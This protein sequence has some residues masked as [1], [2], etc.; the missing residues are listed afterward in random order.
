M[1]FIPLLCTPK[2]NRMNIL[3]IGAN[4]QIGQKI[5]DKIHSNSPHDAI[6]MVRKESQKDQFERRGIKTVLADLEE[7]FEHAYEGNNAVIFTAGSG[8]NTGEDKTKLI[9]RQAAIKS[10]DLAVKHNYKRF[11]MVSAFGAD[12]NSKDWPENMAHYY[13][14]KS[15]ADDYLQQTNLNYTI[16]KPGM[17]TNDGPNGKVDYGERTDERTGKIPRSDVA[18]VIVKSLDA[19]NTYRKS[20]ELLSGPKNIGEAIEKI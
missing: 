6:A 5:V 10:I 2:H 17:L 13:S 14:A 20:L 12:F 19:E 4:G 1:L 9:D 16:V 8:G 11:M 3:V 15:A 18:E 7:D